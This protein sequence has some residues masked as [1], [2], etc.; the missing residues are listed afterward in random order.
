MMKLIRH[1]IPSSAVIPEL[2]L[3][4][5]FYL[6]KVALAPAGLKAF[7]PLRVWCPFLSIRDSWGFLRDLPS[8]SLSF[9]VPFS[10]HLTFSSHQP[11]EI[12]S[13]PVYFCTSALSYLPNWGG[14]GRHSAW[15]KGIQMSIKIYFRPKCWESF[16]FF[17][18]IASWQWIFKGSTEV[19]LIHS[20]NPEQ[21][22]VTSVQR[23]ELQPRQ[24][25]QRS[26][27]Q[28][29]LAVKWDTFYYDQKRKVWPKKSWRCFAPWLTK[30]E[31]KG[32]NQ[33]WPFLITVPKVKYSLFLRW[34]QSW[35][36]MYSCRTRVFRGVVHL[37]ATPW[38]G[39]PVSLKF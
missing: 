12:I 1:V 3:K 14:Y 11:W 21:S 16:F 39:W 33:L 2:S 29:F 34:K 19:P 27:K 23:Y 37:G 15:K 30:R 28:F 13:P 25:L 7:F 20:Q 38:S 24:W 4:P 17:S 10:L 26:K 36:L 18:Y 35:S 6:N 32:C 5:H 22:H 31:Y 8:L 9:S